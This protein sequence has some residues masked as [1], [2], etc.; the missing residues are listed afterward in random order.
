[1]RAIIDSDYM[2]IELAFKDAKMKPMCGLGWLRR[3]LRKKQPEQKIT[4]SY[5]GKTIGTVNAGTKASRTA[6]KAVMDYGRHK[7]Y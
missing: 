6:L 5:D 7:A 1:M 2:D 3:N 4:I